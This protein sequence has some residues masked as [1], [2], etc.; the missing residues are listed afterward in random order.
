MTTPYVQTDALTDATRA[1]SHD[2]AK[3]IKPV[4][5][6]QKRK[7]LDYIASRPDGA[8]D[9]E[10]QIGLDIGPNSERPRRVELFED[11]RIRDSGRK[12]KTKS[13]RAAVVWVA[14]GGEA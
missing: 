8:T 14:T 3:A 11:G 7:V 4:A 10:I 12:R 5:K 2:A 1:T 9:E 6:T 13:G